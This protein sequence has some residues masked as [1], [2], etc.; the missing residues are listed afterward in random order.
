MP[1]F[2]KS[3]GNLAL[4]LP[5]PILHGKSWPADTLL[6]RGLKLILQKNAWIKVRVGAGQSKAGDLN[7]GR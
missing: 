4:N 2:Q 7:R 5:E 1:H 6:S 3:A